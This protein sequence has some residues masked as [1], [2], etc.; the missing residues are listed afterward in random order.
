MENSF[1]D[2]QKLHPNIS[3]GAFAYRKFL[4]SLS[5]D[6]LYANATLVGL[7]A[8]VYRRQ[9]PM[10]LYILSPVSDRKT[11][12]L[13]LILEGDQFVE[14]YTSRY[15]AFLSWSPLPIMMLENFY[16]LRQLFWLY[17]MVI[18]IPIW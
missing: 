1:V 11:F 8:Y 6:L 14:W 12:L 9:L 3:G 4:G 16:G 18:K 15:R 10:K 7:I 17:S 13:Y 5:R 2:L